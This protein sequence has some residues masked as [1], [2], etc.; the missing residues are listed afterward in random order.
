MMRRIFRV[1][2]LL[3][4]PAVG[5]CY[6]YQAI[7]LEDVRPDL[8]IRVRVAPEGTGR[9]AQVMGYLTQDVEGTLVSL[10]QDTA[11]LTVVTPT[12]PE[13]RTIQRLYQR[14]EIPASQIIE[15]RQRTFNAGKTY[16]CVAVGAAAAAGV[17][18]WA[19]SGVFGG[20]AEELPPPVNNQLVPGRLLLPLGHLRLGR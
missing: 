10:R 20:N 5:G 7:R 13:A 4:L 3:A 16:A 9:V 6:S 18:V 12:A 15:V 11:L 19:F 17:A 1:L 8:D 14:L 2:G